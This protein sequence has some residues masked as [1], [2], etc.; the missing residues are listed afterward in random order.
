MDKGAVMTLIFKE[1][2]KRWKAPE[3]NFTVAIDSRTNRVLLYN[4]KM[5]NPGKINIP[6][7]GKL[8]NFWHDI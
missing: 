3:D 7:V 2:G 4:K 5:K 1:C 6:M 8:I